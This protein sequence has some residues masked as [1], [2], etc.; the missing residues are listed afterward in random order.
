MSDLTRSAPRTWGL[1]AA[2][3][4]LAACSSDMAGPADRVLTGTWGAPEAVFVANQASA[5]L[6][7]GCNTI[8]IRSPVTLTEASTFV[9]RGDWHSS[10]LVVGELPRVY[11]R[12][13]LKGTELTLTALLSALGGPDTTY[14]LK[15][16]VTHSPADA[17]ECPF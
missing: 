5:E 8:V 15:A 4:L 12:G 6:R 2:L 9:A 13:S 10:Q 16:G 14:R 3:L 17:P 11:V 7:L 1:P